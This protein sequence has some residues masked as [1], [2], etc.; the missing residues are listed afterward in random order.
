MAKH[1]MW[2]PTM[3]ARK[4]RSFWLQDIQADAATAPLSGDVTADVAIEG[5][6]A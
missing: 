3:A 4:D 5:G 2:T 1:R 6:G